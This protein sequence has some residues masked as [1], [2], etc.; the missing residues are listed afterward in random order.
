M[1][2]ET[3]II[4]KAD[5]V[6][7]DLFDHIDR[8]FAEFMAKL[9]GS[10]DPELL[11]AARLVSNFTGKGNV[12]IHIPS[13][14]G[15]DLFDILDEGY[16]PDEKI[17]LFEADKWVRK[18]R[19]YSCVGKPGD[20]KPLTLDDNS[21]LYLY[22]YWDY[23]QRLALNI[24]NRLERG[25]YAVNN[26][27]LK[28]N[29]SLL[30]D[31][32][33]AD[34]DQ[35]IASVNAL[36]QRFTVISGGPGTGKTSTIIKIL[37]LLIQQYP[38]R[39]DPLRIALAAPTGKAAARLNESIEYALKTVNCQDNIKQLIPR[40]SFTIHRL[41]GTLRGQT[42]FRYNVT[43]LLPYDIVIIDEASMAD[44]ALM[45]R[46]LEAVP[47]ESRIVLLG[48][49]DQLSSVEAGAVLGDIC[50]TGR[51]HGFTRNFAER[52]NEFLPDAVFSE[53]GNDK[54]PL[55]ADSI[56][57][58]RTSY[59]F[60]PESGIGELSRLINEGNADK[61][62]ELLRQNKFSDVSY[63][64]GNITGLYEFLPDKIISGYSPYLKAGKPEE[65]L[66]KLQDFTILCALRKGPFGIEAINSFAEDILGRRGL[67][68]RG[69]RWYDG[70]PVMIKRNAY[71]LRLYNGDIGILKSDPEDIESIR[72]FISSQGIIRMIPPLKLPEHETAFSMT[73]HKSQG[74][75][76]NKVLI[77]LPDH[78][79][80]VLSRELLYTAVTRAR[81]QVAIYGSEEII[82]FMIK[83][84]V[85]RT[86]GLRNAVWKK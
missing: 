47:P 34:K 76:F 45:T 85:L 86:S 36:L 9:S 67:L 75:E 43:N 63:I 10:R 25:Y 15:R 16:R 22:R 26:E 7:P 52:I 84:P 44:L 32:E 70:R 1:K 18:L 37:V 33:N 56:M 23:E 49:K 81:E 13:V 48:D 8:E 41:L 14:A 51:A 58:L 21:R 11:M 12:C 30:F 39:K 53:T 83:N 55:I 61:A 59:R 50:D 27:L 62:L 69:D 38:G 28:Q 78:V 66:K 3:D 29:L 4:L 31:L 65:A 60:G 68:K 64:E 57:V 24:K 82:R 80:P 72:F 6:S 2:Q 20:F 17:L 19:K 46:L 74:S 73:V 54:E 42:S 77:L 40:E 79:S 35:L 71:N 5:Q